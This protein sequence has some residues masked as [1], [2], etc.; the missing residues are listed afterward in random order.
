MIN[1][2]WLLIRKVFKDA[3]TC[4]DRDTYDW[5][6]LA[7]SAAVGMYLKLHWYHL[8]DDDVF[9]PVQF[10]TGL[11]IIIGVVAGGV[12]IKAATKADRR[13]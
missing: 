2:I 10:A 1:R 4:P 6:K 12:A 13:D 5:V 3:H 11:S 9:D 7:G 8:K